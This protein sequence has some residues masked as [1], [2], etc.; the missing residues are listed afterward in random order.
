LRPVYQLRQDVPKPWTG[1]FNP[2][3][4]GSIPARPTFSDIAQTTAIEAPVVPRAK[5]RLDKNDGMTTPE[6]A[7]PVF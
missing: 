3:V 1:A 6:S 4:A 2:K 7:S 5:N